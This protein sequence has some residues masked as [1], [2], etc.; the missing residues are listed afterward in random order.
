[1][2]EVII[3]LS[4]EEEKEVKEVKETL[5]QLSKEQKIKLKGFYEGLRFAHAESWSNLM[6]ISS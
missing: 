3:K 5:E 4:K 2:A 6:W 1:M